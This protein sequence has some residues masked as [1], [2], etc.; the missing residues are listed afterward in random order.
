MTKSKL[1]PAQQKALETLMMQPFAK[2]KGD[3]ISRRWRLMYMHGGLQPTVTI[4]DSVVT[5]LLDHALIA[6]QPDEH[7]SRVYIANA[8]VMRDEQDSQLTPKP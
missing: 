2:I 8:K 5:A 4:R 7:G 1:T 6:R 3:Y